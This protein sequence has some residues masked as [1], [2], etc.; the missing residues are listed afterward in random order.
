MQYIEYK[1]LMNK[2]L[3]IKNHVRVEEQLK[4]C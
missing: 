3:Q 2:F 1:P 4:W